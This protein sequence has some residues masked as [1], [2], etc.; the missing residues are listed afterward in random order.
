MECTTSN[1]PATSTNSPDT[2]HLKQIIP[3]YP[4]SLF[5]LHFEQAITEM[6]G[7]NTTGVPRGSKGEIINF[8]KKM[9]KFGHTGPSS[10]LKQ[11]AGTP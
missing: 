10:G 11:A 2:T 5:S 6:S 1:L 3:I 9:K 8:R 7:L 4:H